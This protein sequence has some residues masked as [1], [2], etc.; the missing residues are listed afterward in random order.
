[1]SILFTVIAGEQKAYLPIHK[2]EFVFGKRD[3]QEVTFNLYVE[4]I[5]LRS[6]FR[7]PYAYVKQVIEESFNPLT[8]AEWT[9]LRQ[10]FKDGPTAACGVAAALFNRKFD[11]REKIQL[12]E[13]ETLN[14][15]LEIIQKQIKEIESHIQCAQE[16]YQE[17]E[18]T[19]EDRVL[20]QKKCKEDIQKYAKDKETLQRR[21]LVLTKQ[22]SDAER[23]EEA[24]ERAFEEMQ[25]KAVC[26]R[27][28][29]L[30]QG[31]ESKEEL[32]KELQELEA[33]L[34]KAGVLASSREIRNQI[35]A[36]ISLKEAQIKLL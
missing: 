21:I 27:P 25:E 4:K 30:L 33:K 3:I 19:E 26:K 8:K 29:D 9:N 14:A 23:A 12:L 36:Q 20:R 5:V 34:V 22:V 11:K 35:R 1:M 32:I 16:L 24:L 10:S 28:E 2:G 7:T 18:N 17:L 31:D 15:R 13:D 6:I